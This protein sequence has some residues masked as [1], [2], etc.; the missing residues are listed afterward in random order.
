MDGGVGVVGGL[1]LN[2]R[3]WSFD[4]KNMFGSYFDNN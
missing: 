4:P 3:I 2:F 1:S